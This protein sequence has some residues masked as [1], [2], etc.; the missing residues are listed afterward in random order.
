M[1]LVFDVETTG[2]FKFKLPI[3]DASQPR[4]VQLGASIFDP[5]WNKVGSFVSLIRP[6][7]W[8]IEP[9]AERIHGISE[10]R[11]SRYG[12]PIVAA[13]AVFQGWCE[14][15]M[16]LVGHNVDFDFNMIQREL[17]HLNSDALW[18][19]KKSGATACTMRLGTDVCKLPGPQGYKWPKLEELYR[20]LFPGDDYVPGH[21]AEADL[22]ATASCAIELEKRG[23]LKMPVTGGRPAVIDQLWRK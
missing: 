10:A 20:V 19:K 4:I 9:D 16:Q 12:V 13:L 5:K 11:C 23:I 3:E 22:L 2:L 1:R 14:S 7:G 8:S 15:S 18:L 21:E 6:D 17:A